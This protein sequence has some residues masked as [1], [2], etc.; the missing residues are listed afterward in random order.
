MTLGKLFIFPSPQFLYLQ[1]EERV[2]VTLQH[3]YTSKGDNVGNTLDTAP[4]QR[5][6]SVRVWVCC[7]HF[8]AED[9]G[10]LVGGTLGPPH[11]A[12]QAAGG[13]STSN[14]VNT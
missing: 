13:G 12:A 8:A 10:L 14:E 3:C 11:T 2:V 7:S 6:S 5:K 9:E 1:N 4:A